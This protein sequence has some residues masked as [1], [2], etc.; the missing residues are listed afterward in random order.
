MIQTLDSYDP[1]LLADLFSM[2]CF[3]TILWTSEKL[4]V[5]HQSVFGA[6]YP[7]G[8]L[9]SIAAMQDLWEEVLT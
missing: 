7:N 5:S 8:D 2:L 3:H 9:I 1:L 4:N 6:I